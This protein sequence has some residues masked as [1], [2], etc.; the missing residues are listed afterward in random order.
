MSQLSAPRY[1]SGSHPAGCLAAHP[2]VASTATPKSSPA[3]R[4]N[5]S[6]ERPC[7]A[8]LDAT[9]QPLRYPARQPQTRG[10]VSALGTD[11][12]AMLGC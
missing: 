6:A 4:T 11:H 1:Q 10:P 2:S 8:P 12:R 5:A 9:T 3:C 7:L